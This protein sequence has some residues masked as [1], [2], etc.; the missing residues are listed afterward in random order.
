MSLPKLHDNAQAQAHI[1]RL[2][3]S[4]LAGEGWDE[5]K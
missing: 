2:S 1:I 4:P 3:S 5:G